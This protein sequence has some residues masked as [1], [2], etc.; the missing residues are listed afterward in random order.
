MDCENL[1]CIYQSKGECTVE[2]IGIDMMGMCT[3]CIY[4]DIDNIIL[5]KAKKELLNKFMERDKD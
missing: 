5:E 4:P 2:E 3:T 1:C